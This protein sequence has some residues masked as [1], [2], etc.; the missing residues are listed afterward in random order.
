MEEWDYIGTGYR[1]RREKGLRMKL[2]KL[3]QIML[4]DKVAKEAVKEQAKT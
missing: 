4:E 3:Q 1:V 2:E